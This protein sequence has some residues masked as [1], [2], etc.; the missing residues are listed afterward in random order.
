MI[1]KII[2]YCWF[3]RGEMPEI[4]QRCIASWHQYMQDWEYMEWNEDSVAKYCQE[5]N[6][7][8]PIFNIQYC[9]EAYKAKKYAFVSDY[10]RLWALERLGGLYL[11]VDCEVYKPFE[12]LMERYEAFAGIEGSKYNPIAMCVMATQSHGEWIREILHLYDNR[13]FVF[14]NGQY[15]MTP[16]TKFISD[17]MAQHGFVT[18]GIEQNYKDLHILPV[19]YFSPRLTTG[20]YICTENTYCDHKGLNSWGDGRVSWKQYILG[21][22]SSD[23]R[24]KLIKLKRKLL[25]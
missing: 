22:V 25:G 18:N 19:E 16:N 6:L 23:M 13:H 24:I 8:S 9:T 20:E 3:G 10:V 21:F 17:Y 4:V 7:Q 1:P 2:H 14:A 12:D 15:D 5:N 11:D